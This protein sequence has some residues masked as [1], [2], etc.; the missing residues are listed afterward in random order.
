MVAGDGQRYWRFLTS[1][2]ASYVNFEQEEA[3]FLGAL[4]A[5]LSADGSCL[6]VSNRLFMT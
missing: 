1:D 3:P 5:H 4:P 2:K 6:T